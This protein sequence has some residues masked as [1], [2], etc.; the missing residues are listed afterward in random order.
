MPSD[1]ELVKSLQNSINIGG[2]ECAGGRKLAAEI[3]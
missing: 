2:K 1:L 3:S